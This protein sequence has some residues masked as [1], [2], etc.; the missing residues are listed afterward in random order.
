MNPYFRDPRCKTAEELTFAAERLDHEGA[1]SADTW[2]E[3][4]LLL[5]AIAS[6]IPPGEY[7][8]TRRD[9]AAAADHA[10]TRAGVA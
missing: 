8:H 10:A 6:E 7:P 3:A 5:R 1:A 9:L 2:W 4:A